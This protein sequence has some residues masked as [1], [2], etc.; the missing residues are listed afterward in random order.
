MPLILDHYEIAKINGP[1]NIYCL[2]TKI[3]NDKRYIILFGE[4]HKPYDKHCFD[5]NC[6]D[7]QSDFLEV[8]N[9]FAEN[10]R[11]SFY[12]EQ[13]IENY[14]YIKEAQQ[15]HVDKLSKRQDLVKNASY[16]ARIQDEYRRRGED[17]YKN[18][19]SKKKNIQE[20]GSLLTGIKQSLNSKR[21]IPESKK[22]NTGVYK[23]ESNMV[24]LAK[25]Y[26]SCF[27][28]NYKHIC[29]YPKIKWQYSDIR[30]NPNYYT[31]KEGSTR[32]FN[33]SLLDIGCWNATREM[34]GVLEIK[35]NE[36]PG[37]I[38]NSPLFHFNHNQISFLHDVFYQT[39]KYSEFPT[40]TMDKYIELVDIIFKNR[41]KLVELIMGLHPIKK[42]HEKLSEEYQSIFS[43]LSFE[44]MVQ[45]YDLKYKLSQSL[46]IYEKIRKFLYLV[47]EYIE[48]ENYA[49]FSKL[50]AEVKN[51]KR[52][53]VKA[54]GEEKDKIESDINKL[55]E[56]EEYIKKYKNTERKNQIIDEMNGLGITKHDLEYFGLIVVAKLSVTLDVYLIMR[57][58]SSDDQLTISYFG[59]EHVI[60][61]Y[62]Y[63]CNIVKICKLDYTY[64]NETRKK[65][66][67]NDVVISKKINL[68]KYFLGDDY[69]IPYPSVDDNAVVLYKSKKSSSKKSS[70]KKSSSKKRNLP[71]T[72]RSTNNNQGNQSTRKIKK[73]KHKLSKKER[74]TI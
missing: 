2:K 56:D 40:R 37:G 64:L 24:E 51:L 34:L 8:L 21:T 47:N 58:F 13:F 15:K 31:K 18:L 49:Y 1:F 63:L 67:V 65:T 19:I 62:N 74:V 29:P 71:M 35:P 20:V 54:T 59:N 55:E 39:S 3:P 26:V 32:K 28:K 5:N 17:I 57:I 46:Y 61:V 44:R 30:D 66:N 38:I 14:E 12:L 33:E 11:T 4:E 10:V 69:V 52:R 7:I 73:V 60:S 48:Y 9:K 41:G 43:S 50:V 27:Y 25:M 45:R 22:K 16:T 36:N 42:Q 53:L 72:Y 68:N 70:S 23:P 6:Y